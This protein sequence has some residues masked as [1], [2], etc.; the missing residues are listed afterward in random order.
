MNENVY[1]FRWKDESTTTTAKFSFSYKCRL[2]QFIIGV[3]LSLVFDLF[4]K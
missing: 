3:I 1:L 2:I 4:L